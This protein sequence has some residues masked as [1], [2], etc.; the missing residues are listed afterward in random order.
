MAAFTAYKYLSG[1]SARRC[2]EDSTLYLAGADQLNDVLETQF[3]TASTEAYLATMDATL[4]D[5]ARQ[6][7]GLSTG[8]SPAPEAIHRPLAARDSGKR[9]T[10]RTPPCR[11]ADKLPP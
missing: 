4:A 2:I 10:Q 8:P 11:K 1:G 3:S 7:G 9:T 5:V 6:R